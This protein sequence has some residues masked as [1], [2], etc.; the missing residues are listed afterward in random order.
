MLCFLLLC[1]VSYY[2]VMFLTTM[3]WFL[4]VCFVCMNRYGPISNQSQGIS[5]PVSTRR[6]K[7]YSFW[8]VE[9]FHI[10]PTNVPRKR[11]IPLSL[12]LYGWCT[13]LFTLHT[14]PLSSTS[15]L[16]RATTPPPLPP[17]LTRYHGDDWI[18]TAHFDGQ[19]IAPICC[20]RAILVSFKIVSVFW[21]V[22]VYI[23][24]TR[25]N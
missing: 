21:R 24:W 10:S 6:H 9:M 16:F 17:Y 11:D 20:D 3:L 22:S 7:I 25:F 5:E 19:K 18:S 14:P 12:L 15:Y 13:P 8:P 1:Y 2:Y 4:L 23:C